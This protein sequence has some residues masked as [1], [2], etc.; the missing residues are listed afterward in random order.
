MAK[1]KTTIKE[2]RQ[3]LNIQQ[4]EL[5]EMVG[6]RR[7]TIVNLERGRYNPSLKLAMDIS[8][9]LG[10]TVEEI[11]AFEDEQ[12]H[13][14]KEFRFR[15][16]DAWDSDET[17]I[18]TIL[19]TSYNG[20][21]KIRVLD[22]SKSY[23]IELTSREDLFLQDLEDLNIMSW[24]QKE[25]YREWVMDGDIWKLSITYDNKH[26]ECRGYNGY[27]HRFDMFLKLLDEYLGER[28]FMANQKGLKKRMKETCSKAYEPERI[29][30]YA[31]QLRK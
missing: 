10:K 3:E 8:R 6:V 31:D 27:P 1:L 22:G 26:M 29:G 19:E 2:L 23:T 12:S 28:I 5:A 9:V 17:A 11:F 13:R 14:L 16:A 18:D 24:N 30:T 20:A 7:E 15:W 25:Y 21:L 4:A